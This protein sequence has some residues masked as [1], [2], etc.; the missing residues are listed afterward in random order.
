MELSSAVLDEVMTWGEA[1]PG[2][3]HRHAKNAL[4][5]VQ[6]YVAGVEDERGQRIEGIAG[7]HER[8]SLFTMDMAWVI[9][10]DD[11]FDAAGGAGIAPPDIE[12]IVRAMDD[13]LPT[14]VAS[15]GFP[16]LRARF[17]RY[18]DDEA[19]RRLWVETAA[20]T[21]RSWVLEDQLSRGELQMSYS[22]YLENGIESSAVPHF[23]ATYSLLYGLELPARL[24]EPAVR[25]I[26][27]HLSIQCRLHN[28]LFSVEKERAEGSGANAVL[29][30]DRLLPPELSK[31]FVADE[32]RGYERLLA[33]DIA[34]LGTDDPLSRL[35]RLMPASHQR[36]Y[37]DPRGSY[38][39]AWVPPASRA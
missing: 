10:L 17:A 19:G 21:V 1:L 12:A 32:L 26:A 37:A 39:T 5:F 3:T 38:Q 35:A 25:R 30:M 18:L 11:I 15:Q 31:G 6:G 33:T 22:E 24:A 16:R 23:L 8:F 27:R 14:T 7:G 36:L 34:T 9:W 28:D 29:L 4:T 2:F 13:G 20:S